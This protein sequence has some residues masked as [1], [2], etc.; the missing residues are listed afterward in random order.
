VEVDVLQTSALLGIA[1]DQRV[2]DQL[3]TARTSATTADL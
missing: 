3:F 1:T 2:L